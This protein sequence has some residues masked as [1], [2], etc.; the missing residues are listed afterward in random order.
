MHLP[1][2]IYISIYILFVQVS[3]TLGDRSSKR[4]RLKKKKDFL[5]F[6]LL[7]TCPLKKTSG[8]RLL[9][10]LDEASRHTQTSFMQKLFLSFFLSQI[11]TF[12]MPF[13]LSLFLLLLLSF[14]FFCLPSFLVEVYIHP[15]QGTTTTT[16][17]THTQNIDDETQSTLDH[18]GLLIAMRN[19]TSLLRRRKANRACRGGMNQRLSL[20]LFFFFFFSPSCS[21]FPWL[22]LCFLR[23]FSL[24][25]KEEEKMNID[26]ST[27]LE[28]TTSLEKEAAV[29]GKV[30]FSFLPSFLYSSLFFW[31]SSFSTVAL[32]LRFVAKNRG[33]RE[34]CSFSSLYFSSL[35][36]R[37]IEGP[38]EE[39]EGSGEEEAED[40]SS[41]FSFS[42][43]GVDCVP[44]SLV[45]PA[46]RGEEIDEEERLSCGLLERTGWSTEVR[47]EWEDEDEDEEEAKL[48]TD[49]DD[50]E[51]EED[52]EEEGEEE[53]EVRGEE[54]FLVE[55]SL[56]PPWAW[57]RFA[58]LGGEAKTWRWIASSLWKR[59]KEINC[60]KNK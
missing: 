50:D 36:S 17:T 2:Y 52:E 41:S 19:S 51:E 14:L 54:E 60:Q 15:T 23:P 10:S 13:L 39:E 25:G 7:V 9:F 45:F 3:R 5:S 18:R 28:S 58:W 20:S 40:S 59:K 46:G 31:H 55:S 26:M 44:D 1:I 48:G 38:G 53:E 37:A 33:D 30:V 34:E 49:D 27:Q 29:Q 32:S 6:S 8:R 35:S 24:T 4:G 11:F 56:L 16:T 42:S 43:L 57:R 21:C 12:T 47:E 22:S